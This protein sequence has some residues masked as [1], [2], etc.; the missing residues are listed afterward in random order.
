MNQLRLAIRIAMD[1]GLGQAQI[2]STVMEETGNI[3]DYPQ[4]EEICAAD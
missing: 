3:V 1:Q 4:R 2:L